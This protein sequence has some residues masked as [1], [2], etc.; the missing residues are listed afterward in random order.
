MEAGV[1]Q[2]NVEVAF[3]FR[4]DSE[5]SLRDFVPE[6]VYAPVSALD[7]QE[8]EFPEQGH[9]Y[10][11]AIDEA[12]HDP[13]ERSLIVTWSRRAADLPAWRLT[14]DEEQ[15]AHSETTPATPLA[16][17]DFVLKSSTAEVVLHVD[18]CGYARAVAMRM[19]SAGSRGGTP[20]RKVDAT[21]TDGG[22]SARLTPGSA[23][24]RSNQISG[25]ASSESFALADRVAISHAVIGETTSRDRIPCAS[26]NS[27]AA[28]SRKGSPRAIQMTAQVSSR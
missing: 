4:L 10:A 18:G 9:N 17:S 8:R 14:Y 3:A 11:L 16:I 25:L 20:G 2:G 12:R 27:R 7:L 23:Q 13:R 19:R 15:L 21:S 22:M 6:L 1:G 5:R 24:N 28:G 26:L